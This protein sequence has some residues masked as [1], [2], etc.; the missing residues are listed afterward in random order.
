MSRAIGKPPLKAPTTSTQLVH[1]TIAKDTT[2]LFNQTHNAKP[3]A[4]TQPTHANKTRVSTMFHQPIVAPGSQNLTSTQPT[5][6]N[7][8]RI[9]QIL[10]PSPTK[11]TISG[12]TLITLKTLVTVYNDVYLAAKQEA[13]EILNKATAS[14]LSQKNKELEA[15]KAQLL[16][17]SD[18]TRF[19]NSFASITSNFCNKQKAAEHAYTVNIKALERTHSEK[20]TVAL[21]EYLRTSDQ[22]TESIIK[23]TGLSITKFQEAGFKIINEAMNLHSFLDSDD[24]E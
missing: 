6:V 9:S 14:I 10:R 19:N 7:G 23:E 3:Q 17:D 12:T 13:Q 18:K 11:P 4:P 20:I 8:T 1:V 16:Q 24:D 21:N 2:Q 15:A 5:L 22:K